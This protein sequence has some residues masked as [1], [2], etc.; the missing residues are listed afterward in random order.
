LLV[1][2]HR[3]IA[4]VG[5]IDERWL[6]EAW[7]ADAPCFQRVVSLFSLCYLLLEELSKSLIPHGDC[8]FVL[9]HLPVF[10][11]NLPV[12]GRKTGRAG[13]FSGLVSERGSGGSVLARKY[14]RTNWA[15]IETTAFTSPVDP[16]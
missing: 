1:D 8:P 10:P 3:Q 6:G 13:G 12:S 9:N 15:Q 11:A 5:E 7:E 14:N 16:A 4:G 2:E